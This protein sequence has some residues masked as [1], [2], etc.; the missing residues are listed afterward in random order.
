MRLI[1]AVTLPIAL[2]P[3]MLAAAPA[4]QSAPASSSQ[5]EKAVA[6]PVLKFSPA[7][8]ELG[9]L[10]IGTPGK[11]TLTI[12]NASDAPITIEAIK[13]GCGCTKVSDP[14]RARS[15]QVRPSPSTSRS[16]PA[17]SQAWSS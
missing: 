16:T 9:E 7:T 13:A 12:T 4:W 15:R 17:P 6:A 8:L 10:M 11:G 3:A 1:P 14:P 5:A 2:L